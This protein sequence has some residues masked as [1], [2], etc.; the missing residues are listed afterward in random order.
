MADGDGDGDSSA[1]LKGTNASLVCEDAVNGD[2]DV[3]IP[4][5]SAVQQDHVYAVHT[6]Y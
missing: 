6:L 2:K 1:T 4:P 5:D 3:D